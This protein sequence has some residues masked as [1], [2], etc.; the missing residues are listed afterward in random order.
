MRQRRHQCG[1]ALVEFALTMGF[2]LAAVFGIT[3]F[4][5]AIYQYDTLAKAARDAA[6][7]LS[8]KTPGDAASI[9]V[10]TC[11]AVYGRTVCSGAPLAT[12]LTTAM[13]SVCDASS[14]AST[15]HAQG[16]APVQDFVTVTIGGGAHPFV[17]SS[18]MPSIVPNITFGAIRATMRQ[19]T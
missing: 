1:L 14:C 8:S 7:Y 17:F 18:M 15:N 9:S 13:V 4:G 5:R 3:E 16:S 19:G 10:A 11:L 2:L 12:G 6:R